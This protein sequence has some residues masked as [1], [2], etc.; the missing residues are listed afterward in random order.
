MCVCVGRCQQ[1]DRT[2]HDT[3][4]HAHVQRERERE[5]R[6]LSDEVEEASLE[7]AGT[8]VSGRDLGG[9]LE[10]GKEEERDKRVNIHASSCRG[11]KREL[12]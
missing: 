6:Y 12:T 2:K 11:G 9:F 5:K 8:G 1:E 3:H 10:G 4:K 7:G